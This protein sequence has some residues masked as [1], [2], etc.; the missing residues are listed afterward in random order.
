MSPVQPSLFLSKYNHSVSVNE[1]F[2]DKKV[3]ATKTDPDL[4]LRHIE[5]L[6]RINNKIK[7][8]TRPIALSCVHREQ[9]QTDGPTDQPTDKAAYRV[10][11]IV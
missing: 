11:K 8:K 6:G 1:S 4:A 7:Q 3:G 5:M 2:Y 9:R 10:A